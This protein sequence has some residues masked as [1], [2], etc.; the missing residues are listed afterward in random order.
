MKQRCT[1][2]AK[3]PT[4]SS[5]HRALPPP[6]CWTFVLSGGLETASPT[7]L[8]FAPAV[9]NRQRPCSQATSKRCPEAQMQ[10]PSLSHLPGRSGTQPPGSSRSHTVK[11]WGTDAF[12]SIPIF[13]VSYNHFEH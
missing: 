13:S 6:C 1:P 7:A 12:W 5:G 9:G 10:L 8:G 11:A 3:C 4:P 2:F